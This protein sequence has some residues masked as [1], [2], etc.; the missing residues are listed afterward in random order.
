VCVYGV[1]AIPAR[2]SLYVCVAYR[3]SPDATAPAQTP[4]V[5]FSFFLFPTAICQTRKLFCLKS[6]KFWYYSGR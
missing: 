6:V 2:L 1:N 5:F 3:W 4:P